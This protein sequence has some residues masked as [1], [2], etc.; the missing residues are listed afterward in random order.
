MLNRYPFSFSQLFL[1]S[2]ETCIP[3]CNENSYCKN[4]RCLCRRG[5]VMG[6]AYTCQPSEGETGIDM[7]LAI[8]VLLQKLV[9]KIVEYYQNN[10][11]QI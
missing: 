2:L 10:E 11:C 7:R 6:L 1:F 5:Y 9:I 3:K 8:K 4:E